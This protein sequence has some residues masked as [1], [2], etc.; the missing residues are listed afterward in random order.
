MLLNNMIQNLLIVPTYRLEDMADVKVQEY[1]ASSTTKTMSL[2]CLNGDP[3]KTMVSDLLHLD[4][5]TADEL[6]SI[7]PLATRAHTHAWFSLEATSTPGSEK[8]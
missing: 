2:D 3:A 5:D 6:T 8:F 4:P 1:L 7:A